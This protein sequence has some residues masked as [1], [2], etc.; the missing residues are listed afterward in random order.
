MKGCPW[1]RLRSLA[2]AG[3]NCFV[4][5]F[6]VLP[7]MPDTAQISPGVSPDQHTAPAAP[8]LAEALDAIR[9]DSQA[10]PE[11]YLEDTVVPH[12]GE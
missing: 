4:P 8:A 9:V 12:G 6:L 10:R 2:A 1:G 3:Q 7:I 5:C 11:Q